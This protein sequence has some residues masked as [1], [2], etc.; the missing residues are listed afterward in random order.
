MP[1]EL[2]NFMLG[3]VGAN[4]SISG[5]TGITGWH[6]CCF[7]HQ[8]CVSASLAR[9]LGVL[10]PYDVFV[11]NVENDLEL[12]I[13]FLTRAGMKVKVA[14]KAPTSPSSP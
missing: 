8:T 14:I 11:W 13:I 10:K 3:G 12:K 5:I 1:T 7:L 2:R 9:A 6:H 4:C